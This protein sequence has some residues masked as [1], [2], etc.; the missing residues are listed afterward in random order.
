MYR[1]YKKPLK[2]NV[3]SNEVRG[4]IFCA[5]FHHAVKDFSLRSK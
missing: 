3:I 4:E 5:M 2:E 1:G